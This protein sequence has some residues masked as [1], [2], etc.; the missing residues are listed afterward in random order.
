LNEKRISGRE[1]FDIPADTS[2]SGTLQVGIITNQ[3]ASQ[4]F[5]VKVDLEN[6]VR[7]SQLAGSVMTRDVVIVIKLT[8]GKDAVI[9][10]DGSAVCMV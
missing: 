1:V 2:R 8:A 4:H 7:A 6:D 10:E 3:P 9:S 5:H